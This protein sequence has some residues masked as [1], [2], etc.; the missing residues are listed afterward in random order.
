VVDI[1]PANVSSMTTMTTWGWLLWETLIMG[2]IVDASWVF[3]TKRWNHL[4]RFS[5]R[6]RLWTIPS[7]SELHRGICWT[8]T[9]AWHRSRLRIS[10]SSLVVENNHR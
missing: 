9:W 4:V 3:Q 2:S 1:T 6:G 7:G 10:S 8:V 5:S